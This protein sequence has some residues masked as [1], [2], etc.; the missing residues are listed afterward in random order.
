MAL[1][2]KN[3]LITPNT[4]T[5]NEPKIEFTGADASGNDTING[6]VIQCCEHR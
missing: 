6:S 5:A 2:D 1:D 4:G 3:I